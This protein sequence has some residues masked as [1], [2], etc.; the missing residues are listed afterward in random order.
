VDEKDLER[1]VTLAILSLEVAFIDEGDLD[2]ARLFLRHLNNVFNEYE[3]SLE[4]DND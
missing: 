2:N 3:Q 4:E 1:E